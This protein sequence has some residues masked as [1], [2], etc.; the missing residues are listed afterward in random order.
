VQVR[1]DSSTDQY[2]RNGGSASQRRITPPPRQVPTDGSHRDS[3]ARPAAGGAYAKDGTASSGLVRP[4]RALG[5]DRQDTRAVIEQIAQLLQDGQATVIVQVAN[6]AVEAEVRTGLEIRVAR[7]QITADRYRDVRFELIP[8]DNAQLADQTFGK[9]DPAALPVVN[10]DA[11]VELPEDFAAF[12]K[13]GEVEDEGDDVAEP[14]TPATLKEA[15][16]AVPFQ[17]NPAATLGGGIDLIATGEQLAKEAAGKTV[18]AD[19]VS[20]SSSDD[21][22]D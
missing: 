20:L 2:Y 13:D 19:A 10:V 1:G 18:D 9:I 15:A 12:V 5:T 21:D 4:L 14:L 22:G 6:A 11:D 7:E 8:A 16:A 17:D 3:K